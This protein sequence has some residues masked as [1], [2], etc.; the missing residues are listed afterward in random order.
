L[1]GAIPVRWIEPFCLDKIED[2]AIRLVVEPR[3][4]LLTLFPLHERRLWTV[5]LKTGDVAPVGHKVRLEIPQHGLCNNALLVGQPGAR[6]DS[7]SALARVSFAI[8]G[9]TT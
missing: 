4:G 2:E 8:A 6:A 1:E 3:R 7:A 9:K 5:S